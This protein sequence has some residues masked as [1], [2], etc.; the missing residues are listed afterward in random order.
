MNTEH[1]NQDRT[2]IAAGLIDAFK[3]KTGTDQC[4]AL[5]DL[6]ADLMHYADVYGFEFN[7]ELRRARGHYAEEAT[8]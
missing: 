5:A 2:A 1:I 6:L 3:G 7:E 8:A 4:D